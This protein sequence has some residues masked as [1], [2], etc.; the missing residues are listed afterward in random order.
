MPIL[1]REYPS[2][3]SVSTF[4]KPKTYF[5]ILYLQKNILH[6][7]AFLCIQWYLFYSVTGRS[8]S[9]AL[10]SGKS[11][12]LILILIR[13]TYMFKVYIN[14]SYKEESLSLYP[15]N[16]CFCRKLSCFHKIIRISFKLEQ[17]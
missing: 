15:R 2:Y 12:L 14:K 5:N 11:A 8:S 16:F 9:V 3:N 7:L 13:L 10:Y 4:F 17:F 6:E 1:I